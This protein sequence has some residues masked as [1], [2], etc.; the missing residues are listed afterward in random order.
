[1][2]VTVDELFTK[3]LS[4]LMKVTEDLLDTKDPDTKAFVTERIRDMQA[5]LQEKQLE[6]EKQWQK[7]INEDE[8]EIKSVQDRIVKLRDGGVED[9]VGDTLDHLKLWKDLKDN[10]W[11]NVYWFFIRETREPV[12]LVHEKL[13]TILNKAYEAAG[14]HMRDSRAQIFYQVIQPGAAFERTR[15]RQEALKAFKNREEELN[16]LS[17]LCQFKAMPFCIDSIKKNIKDAILKKDKIICTVPNASDEFQK[18]I[19]N[20]FIKCI[21]FSWAAAFKDV[22][23]ILLV[24]DPNKE[25]PKKLLNSFEGLDKLHKLCTVEWPALVQGNSIIC[26]WVLRER[27]QLRPSA[28]PYTKEE[29]L[30]VGA[31]ITAHGRT[32]ES[33]SRAEMTSPI[34]TRRPL[35]KPPETGKAIKSIEKTTKQHQIDATTAYNVPSKKQ[36]KIHGNMRNNQNVNF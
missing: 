30:N 9:T 17:A 22:S 26:P 7:E 27:N 28:P 36:P 23:P 31:H 5:F 14:E 19:D 8:K 18:A 13:L 29:L 15:D 34:L 35:P 4:D 11:K 25:C 1:M 21:E 2:A 12:Q 6:A 32:V 10:E 33:Q 20:Y 16:D 3:D 24:T